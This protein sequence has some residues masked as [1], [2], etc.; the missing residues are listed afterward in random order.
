MKDRTADLEI[1]AGSG[2]DIYT[3]WD[4][5]A[6]ELRANWWGA[7]ACYAIVISPPP[8][9]DPPPYRKRVDQNQDYLD[10]T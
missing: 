8:T 1:F 9:Q 6:L 2:T 7:L 5:L 3:C 10:P 4:A